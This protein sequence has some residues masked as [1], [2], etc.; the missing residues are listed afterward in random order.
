M[1]LED[2]RVLT[3]KLHLQIIVNSVLLLGKMCGSCDRQ[4]THQGC[5]GKPVFLHCT[6]AGVPGLLLPNVNG[7]PLIIMMAK[8]TLISKCLQG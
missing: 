3:C 4:G 5:L 7:M 2:S 6:Q 8:V 1:A